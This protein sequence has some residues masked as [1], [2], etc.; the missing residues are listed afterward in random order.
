MLTRVDLAEIPSA[1]LPEKVE[2][3][4]IVPDHDGP[5]PLC[6]VLMGGGGSRQTLA[7]CLPLFEAWWSEKSVAPMILATPSP[8][9]SYYVEDPAA[10]VRWDSFIVEDFVPHLRATYHTAQ[11]A[12][13]GMSMGGYGALKIAFAYPEEFAAVAAMNPMM[14]PG[15]T[16]AEIGARNRLHHTSGGPARLIG[17]SRDP[18]LFASNQPATRARSN[19][20][21]LRNL[22]IYIEA[23][24]NDFV[25]AHDGTEFLHR[26]L[27]D[28]DLSHEYR[29]YRGADHGGPTFRPRMHEMYKWLTR[30]LSA[31][32]LTD[33]SLE[34]IRAQLQPLRDQAAQADPATRRRF[35]NLNCSPT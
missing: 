28:L 19:A 9:M 13:T 21:R 23:G 25:N 22:P 35:A 6:L 14:E 29:L 17:P 7:A 24:D 26:V 8:G 2:Y 34:A 3:A 16:D 30:I 31:E 32:P 33:A 20:D 11:T 1:H 27:W 12:I 5:L 18:E 4:A 10:G 15:F